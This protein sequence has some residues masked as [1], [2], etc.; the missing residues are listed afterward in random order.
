MNVVFQLR[1]SCSKCRLLLAK[2]HVCRPK[3]FFFDLLNESI[4]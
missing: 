1:R 3:R 4:V 2:S